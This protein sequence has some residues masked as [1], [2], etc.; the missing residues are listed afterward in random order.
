MK[1]KRDP[2]KIHA[3]ENTFSVVTRDG[4]AGLFLKKTRITE[5]LNF[6]RPDRPEEIALARVDHELRSLNETL[7]ENC[8]ID[9]IPLR[10]PEGW[11]A[12]QTTLCLILIRAAAEC[13]PDRILVIDHSI[14]KGLYCEW[15]SGRKA[16]RWKIR[17]IRRRMEEIIRRDEIIEPLLLPRDEA[18]AGLERLGSSETGFLEAGRPRV[19]MAGCGKSVELFDSPLLPSSGRIRA[20]DLIAWH[21]GMIL[22]FPD[23]R[24]LET[25]P[26]F[27]PQRR[28]FRVFNESGE[29]EKI[30]GIR[31][32]AD[33]NR[34][35][36]AGAASD[37]I[38]IAEGLHEKK[39][40]RIADAIALKRRRMRLIL[41]A[42]P[43]SSG[44]TTFTKRL[45]VQLRVNGLRPLM[46]SLDDYF[47]D[48]EKTP[49]GDDGKP[50]Y[51]AVGAV[52]I[53][54]FNRDLSDLMAGRDI[55]L[56]R[57]DFTTGRRVAGPAARIEPGHPILVEGLHALNGRLT[58]AL[59]ERAKFRIYVSALTQLNLT[60]HM[61]VAT[62]DIRFLR[63][64]I[65]DAQFRNHSAL[66]SL[67]TWPLVRR[68]E[69]KYI[70]P[71]QERSHVIFNSALSY[72]PSV[73]R[74]YGE[75]LLEQTPKIH[76]DYPEAWR[77]L[78]LLRS[79][80]PVS[81]AEV[82]PTS[83]IREFIGGSSFTY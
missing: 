19:A 37:L 49:V 5:I 53:S 65:R 51:E 15:K 13:V 46:I 81:P 42:G 9:W 22:R 27:V 43:S 24:N 35:I 36:A 6:F 70:F 64:L 59:P 33:L 10:S 78:R 74:A 28:L 71:F 83:I 40:A 2:L 58:E 8:L 44:K 18:E 31:Y 60:D 68:G 4:T 54:R 76:P 16:G 1:G 30:Q 41:I 73:L 72:E 26:P 34:I 25:L 55:A 45:N 62:S 11:R 52:D 47:L 63:R 57:Y 21:S 29:W 17:A 38:R 48:R 14:G 75:P 3:R 12:Y 82:P 80:T 50:D 66:D 56:P 32:A 20:W 7:E 77:L 39:V 23:E 69:E 61:R 67:S 79:F